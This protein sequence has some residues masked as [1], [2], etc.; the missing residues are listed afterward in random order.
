MLTNFQLTALISFAVTA[1][2]IYASISTFVAPLAEI[3]RALG[4]M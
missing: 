4:G 3:A 2:L 1:P